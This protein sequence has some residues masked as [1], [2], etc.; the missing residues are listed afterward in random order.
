MINC[1]L[2]AVASK[3]NESKRVAE[4]LGKLMAIQGLFAGKYDVCC[5][6]KIMD[7]V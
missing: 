7:S 6:W 4:N 1:L 3:I 5:W 2:K